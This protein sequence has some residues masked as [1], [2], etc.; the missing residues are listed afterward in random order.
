[1]EKH[2]SI[3]G[4]GGNKYKRIHSYGSMSTRSDDDMTVHSQLF[5]YHK[6]MVVEREILYE[7]ENPPFQPLIATTRLFGKARFTCLL[8]IYVIFYV[9]YLASG[10]LVFSALEAPLENQIRLELIRAKTDFLTRYPD[11]VGKY[12][13]KLPTFYYRFFSYTFYCSNLSQCPSISLI[14]N[15]K[16]SSPVV[17]FFLLFLILADM[18]LSEDL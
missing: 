16:L 15:Y 13:F 14:I 18:D 6:K 11:I 12:V 17:G 5:P 8:L 2:I 7:E 4:N 9:V 1:M 10:A 3:G